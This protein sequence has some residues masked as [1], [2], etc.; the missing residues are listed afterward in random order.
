MACWSPY[1]LRHSF[2]CFSQLSRHYRVACRGSDCLWRSFQ[3]VGELAGNDSMAGRIVSNL[4]RVEH[5][6]TG[7]GCWYLSGAYSHSYTRVGDGC[8]DNGKWELCSQKHGWN[9]TGVRHNQ[10]QYWQ[11]QFYDYQWI[12]RYWNTYPVGFDHGMAG[13]GSDDER[14]QPY[15]WLHDATDYRVAGRG[16]YAQW[17]NI[18]Q[19]LYDTAHHRVACWCADS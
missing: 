14:N 18:D 15:Q 1:R 4:Y 12:D 10:R 8:G 3:C 11:S 6:G 2:K 13:S 17:D 7:A 5:Y 19:W 16:A 9:H